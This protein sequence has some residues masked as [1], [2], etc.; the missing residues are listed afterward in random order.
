MYQD[1]FAWV[2]FQRG[3]R[4]ELAELLGDLNAKDNKVFLMGGL[5]KLSIWNWLVTENY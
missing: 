2:L 3:Q 5:L 4:A 1:L